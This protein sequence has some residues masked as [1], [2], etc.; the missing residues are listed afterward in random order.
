VSSADRQRYTLAAGVRLR[1][2]PELGACLAYTPASPLAR[3]ALHLLNASSWLIAA[4]CD[5]RP[6]AAVAAG[7]RAAAAEDAALAANDATLRD[8]IAQLVASGVLAPMSPAGSAP[9]A[10]A[11]PHDGSGP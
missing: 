4:L 3:P 9:R 2:V 11:P 6:A 1:P 10:A 5:G 8:G 7:F